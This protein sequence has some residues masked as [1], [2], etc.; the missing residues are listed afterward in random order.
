[1][2][3][4]VSIS[5]LSNRIE[6]HGGFSELPDVVQKNHK[7]LWDGKRAYRPIMQ[8]SMTVTWPTPLPEPNIEKTYTRENLQKKTIL[9]VRANNA[10]ILA[11][12]QALAV[13]L[14]SCDVRSYILTTLSSQM[15]CCCPEMSCI[16]KAFGKAGVAMTGS[17]AKEGCSCKQDICLL[18][19]VA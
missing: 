2:Q 8:N 18:S 17:C 7:E 1:M 11:L 5:L 9:E 4:P 10:A 15:H 12:Q 13:D 3:Q 14:T 6:Q 16:T 19:K